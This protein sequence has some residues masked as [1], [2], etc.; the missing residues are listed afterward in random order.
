MIVFLDM[1]GVLCQWHEAAIQ[2]MGRKAIDK[3]SLTAPVAYN[4]HEHL[5]VERQEI[6]L[7]INAEGCSWWAD[8]EPTPWFNTLMQGMHFMHVEPVILSSSGRF[9]W[10]PS[11]KLQWLRK[12]FGT[13]FA[14][15]IFTK[16]KHL[17]ARPDHI[18]IDDSEQMVKRFRDNSGHAILFPQIW[19]SGWNTQN[20][21]QWLFDELAAKLNH[22]RYIIPP[23][24]TMSRQQ[25]GSS[26]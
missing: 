16:H 24:D 2:L 22:A 25:Q 17:C 4:V 15:Y 18:L 3:S 12:R 13:H 26:R 10:A 8:L 6:D 9:P 14:D 7:R 21:M 1:D 20:P 11:G 5:G 23:N 19:N